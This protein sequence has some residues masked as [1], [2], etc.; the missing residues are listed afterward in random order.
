MILRLRLDRFSAVVSYL[1]PAA[2]AVVIVM[3][4]WT[5]EYVAGVGWEF[6]EY[7]TMAR[8]LLRGQGATSSAFLPFDLALKERMVPRP[9]PPIGPCNRNLLPTWLTALA[10]LA[11][12]QRDLAVILPHVLALVAF[13][14]ITNYLERRLISGAVFP[15]AATI[16]ACSPKVLL[17]VIE[18]YPNV[19]YG[20]LF[21]PFL[22]LLIGAASGRVTLVG[23]LGLGLFG[24][25]AYLARSDFLLSLPLALAYLAVMRKRSSTGRAIIA[26]LAGVIALGA[27]EWVYSLRNFGTALRSDTLWSNLANIELGTTWVRYVTLDRWELLRRYGWEYVWGG[28]RYLPVCL[29]ALAGLQADL[30][31][32][33]GK[34][35]GVS[36]MLVGFVVLSQRAWR[37]GQWGPW[38]FTSLLCAGNAYFFTVV[39]PCTLRYLYW[40]LPLFGLALSGGLQSLAE[41]LSSIGLGLRRLRLSL[42]LPLVFVLIVAATAVARAWTGGMRLYVH[43]VNAYYDAAQNDAVMR[44]ILRQSLAVN[45]P[46]LREMIPEDAILVGDEPAV[47]WY[48]DRLLMYLPLD[49]ASFDAVERNWFPLNYI[50]IGPTLW[51][52]NEQPLNWIYRHYL[53]DEQGIVPADREGK[54]ARFLEHFPEFEVW[55]RFENGGILFRRVALGRA[56]SNT[57]GVTKGN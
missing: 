50:Y 29:R 39:S 15:V 47:A 5:R 2:V 35:I 21:V 49:R 31:G 52:E 14:L 18:A 3:G 16:L 48:A 20:A 32:L 43:G 44:E 25:L 34:V 7:G 54:I 30:F 36:L 1:F 4:I 19:L 17:T 22:W 38:L 24:G 33:S 53:Q 55:I 56:L 37:A 10:M 6:A 41:Y 42:T 40:M 27:F 9:H 51:F 46:T 8:N 13:V 23:L 57:L 11:F 28:L 26:I 12:G 45:Y